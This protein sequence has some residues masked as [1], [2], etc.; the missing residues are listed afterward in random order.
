MLPPSPSKFVHLTTEQEDVQHH[1][2]SGTRTQAVYEK[3]IRRARKEAFKSS[4]ALVKLQEELKTARNRYTLMREEAEEH[5]R[6]LESKEQETFAAQL[7]L[8]SMEG[9]LEKVRQLL[10]TVEQERD[11][12]R[13]SLKEEEV[14]RIAAEGRIPL[15]P[16]ADDDEFSSP[17]KFQH[18]PPVDLRSESNETAATTRSEEQDSQVK[19]LKLELGLERRLRREAQEIVTFMKLE[20]QLQ[21]C[22]CRRAEQDG[23]RYIHDQHFRTAWSARPEDQC[24]PSVD[25]SM[26]EQDM[27]PEESVIIR[28]ASKAENPIPFSPMSEDGH[29]PPSPRKAVPPPPAVEEKGVTAATVNVSILSP[30]TTAPSLAPPL[31]PTAL[32]ESPSLL[33][34]PGRSSDECH[35]IPSLS[36]PTTPH[37]QQTETFPNSRSA[38]CTVPA[39]SEHEERVAARTAP[40]SAPSQASGNTPGLRLVTNT[41]TTKV[42]LADPDAESD[43]KIPTAGAKFPFSPGATKTREEAL[44]S[45]QRWRQG[46]ARARSVTTGST[47]TKRSGTGNGSPVRRDISAPERR[48]I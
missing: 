22:S 18:Q 17:R 28:P 4:S 16:S 20:C 8:V 31:A 29:K 46:R 3:E 6:R 34:L 15:P 1:K 38:P 27:P 42:P 39:G 41:T 47:S 37:Q 10:M 13:T 19:C 26:Q 32:S 23:G 45:I 40:A 14:A 11:A 35:V 33:S 48:G 2:E 44:Q 21:A 5:K 25:I 24:G 7:K 36:T 12:L 30:P 43:R 9:E